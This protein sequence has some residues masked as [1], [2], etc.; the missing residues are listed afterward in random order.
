[1]TKEKPPNTEQG[2]YD[3][4][5]DNPAKSSKDFSWGHLVDVNAYRCGQLDRQ[6]LQPR[7]PKYDRQDYDPD[8]FERN[9]PP[10]LFTN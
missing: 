8:T 9:P 5:Y 2:C 4:G 3:L 10:I 7:N 6:N 1:V